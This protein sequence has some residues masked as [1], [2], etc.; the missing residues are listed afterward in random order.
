MVD[1]KMDDPDQEQDRDEKDHAI[2]EHGPSIGEY[3][4]ES[5]PE[6]IV[7]SNGA[8]F[9]FNR[10]AIEGYGGLEPSQLEENEC[11]ISPGLIYRRSKNDQTSK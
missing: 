11:L 2:V 10:I 5:I 8:R 3:R 4:R 7:D 1:G 6:Y 9:D